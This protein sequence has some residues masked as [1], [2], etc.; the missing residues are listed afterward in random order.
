MRKI[1][2]GAA[3]PALLLA[4]PLAAHSDEPAAGGTTVLAGATILTPDRTIVPLRQALGAAASGGRAELAIEGIAYDAPPHVLYQVSLQ[5]PGGRLAPLGVINFYNA[6]A[7]QHAARGTRHFDATEALRRL[8]GRAIALV[9]EPTAG[10]TGV[11]AQIDPRSHV[12]FESVSIR[13][14]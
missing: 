3:V 8:G 2:M 14:R 4:G 10:V 5:G 9:F 11:R 1:W 7:P 12:R 6:T 13:W